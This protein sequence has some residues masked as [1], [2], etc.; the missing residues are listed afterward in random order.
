MFKKIIFAAM[1]CVAAIACKESGTD[2]STPTSHALLNKQAPGIYDNDDNVFIYDEDIHQLAFNTQRHTFRIQNTAQDRYLICA[3]DADPVAN[4]RVT[5]DVK[6]RGIS[7]FPSQTLQV[8]VLKRDQGKVWL[9]NEEK[10][11]GFVIRIE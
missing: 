5:V 11:A 1:V 6:T 8:Q 3:L 9:W 4:N 2:D 10:K 7:R